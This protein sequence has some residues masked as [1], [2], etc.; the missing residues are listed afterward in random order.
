MFG[1]VL[2]SVLVRAGVTELAAYTVQLV[3][4]VGLNVEL[5]RR[6]TWR[7]RRVRLRAHA[8]SAAGRVAMAIASWP[9]FLLLTAHFRIGGLVANALVVA[10]G[11]TVNFTVGEK[12]AYRIRA[13]PG[14]LVLTPERIPE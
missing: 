14:A 6:T 4:T 10:F 8:L 2:Q 11:M 12:L 1:L 9:L 7:N 13:L 3:V 5:N